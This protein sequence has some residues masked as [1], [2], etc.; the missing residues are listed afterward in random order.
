MYFNAFMVYIT[1]RIIIGGHICIQI[2]LKPDIFL[3]ILQTKNNRGGDN[4][5]GNIA[6]PPAHLSNHCF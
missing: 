2:K 5:N 3:E 1:F 4:C 6:V